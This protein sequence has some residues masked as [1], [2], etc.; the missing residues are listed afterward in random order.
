VTKTILKQETSDLG[1]ESRREERGSC[2]VAFT[3]SGG[4]DQRVRQLVFEDPGHFLQI[5]EGRRCTFS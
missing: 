5:F 3:F 2:H 1:S 4:G